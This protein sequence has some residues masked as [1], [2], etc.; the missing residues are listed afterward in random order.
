MSELT[1]P[2]PTLAIV[3][4]LCGKEIYRVLPVEAEKLPSNDSTTEEKNV[5][6]L[7]LKLQDVCDKHAR[8]CKELRKLHI[9]AN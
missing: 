1:K 8:V 9:L 4:D 2:L 6:A 7:T 5:A 3:C